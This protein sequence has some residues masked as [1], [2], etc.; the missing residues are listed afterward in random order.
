MRRRLAA[1]V[2]TIV[3]LALTYGLMVQFLFAKDKKL[4][5]AGGGQMDLTAWRFAG[6]GVIP[7]DGEWQ[8]YPDEL[9]SSA[10]IRDRVN[11]EGAPGTATIHVPGSW[12]KQMETLGK[13]T[14]RLQV[15]VGAGDAGK[16]FGL[17]TLSLQMSNRILVNGIEVGSSG[18]AADKL[19]YRA[20]NKPY[21]SYFTLQPGWNEIVVQV[22]N[23]DFQASSG[24]MNSISFG[25]SDQISRLRDSGII[26]D[27][28]TIACFLIIGLYFIGLYAQ[29]KEDHSLLYFGLVCLLLATFSSTRGERLLLILFDYVPYWL[30]IRLQAVSVYGVSISFFLYVYTAF[31]PYCSQRMVYAGVAVGVC[32]T[33]WALVF[34]DFTNTTPML[35]ITTVY[36]TLPYM[37][38]TYVLVLAALHR[39]EGSVYLVI[40]ALALNHY[41][42]IQSLN[43][44][45]NVALY[46]TVPFEV[47][48][49]LLM[50]ALMMSL[51]FSNAFKK[52]EQL[53]VQLMNVDKLKDEFL[54]RTS[55]EFK[56]PL[57]SVITISQ[58]MLEDPRHPL[59]PEQSEK[60]ELV[61]SVTKK[62]S[63]LVFDILDLSKLK[64]G[65]L[66]VNPIAVDVRSTVEMVLRIF[67]YL[68]AGKDVQ[69]INS[70]PEQ[71]PNA[72]AD[73]NRFR[74]ILNNLVDNAVKYTDRG[75]IEVLAV[76]QDGWLE[77]SV[78]DTGSGIAPD[79]LQHIFEPFQS[80]EST[81]AHSF[82]LGLSIVKQL[83]ELQHGRITVASVK[84]KGS[85]FTFSLPVAGPAERAELGTAHAQ[86][87]YQAPEYSFTTPYVLGS[88]AGEQTILIA[89]DH[90]A[91]LKILIDALEPL[92]YNLIAVQNGF[93]AVEQIEQLNSI[94]LV[95]LDLMMPGMS[96][97]DVCKTIRR[98]YSLL[99]MPVLMVTTAVEPQD[100][101]AAF[102]AGANDFLP[103]PFDTTELK[104]RVKGL[105]LMKDTLGQAIKM[106]MAFLQSQIKPHFLYNVLNTI[107]AL[108]Y[109]DE[110]KS[111][112][113]TIDLADYMRGSFRFSNTQ[114]RTSFGQ[115]LSL[116]RS[117]VEIEHA[118]FKDRL[119]VEYDIEE[120]M[121]GVSIPPLLLQPLVENA[122]R[123]GIG[124]RTEGGT[125]TISARA[126]ENH[127][128][129]EIADNGVGI[130]PERLQQ[131][132]RQES[133]TT[134]G[135]GLR[136]IMKRLKYE[137]NTEL[138][139]ESLPAIGTRVIV[140]IPL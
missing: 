110:E 2:I 67:S 113:L 106:E 45:S 134:Y 16:I 103:K 137:Y 127:Y 37:Y 36:G 117:Y 81:P 47:F 57:Q 124:S 138:R 51:R 9:L 14:Y 63:Q 8:F 97:Y 34:I 139:M 93:E 111:R 29:R 20:G 48:L 95:I 22:A 120:S 10:A 49:V 109:T 92:G 125:V 5:L 59:A 84:G 121:Q 82:G 75:T 133:G 94:D 68:T 104:A 62:L 11:R 41:S 100:K 52:V 80:F 44:Y 31:R 66:M 60:L 53:S 126:E 115:E 112:K 108:S 1:V 38:T 39:A 50:L 132:L 119:R 76:E 28:I 89:D 21:V 105:L 19:M 128:C 131:L 26:H 118:R 58:S 4:P 86:L 69:L 23:Y 74:Q 70:V 83:V 98:T 99:E 64:Q 15:R 91:N 71:L 55:H 87:K 35:L 114:K 135:V 90:Y 78:Q 18:I 6:D 79:E 46:S 73:E 102:E 56:A 123:H 122:I 136:N 42:M 30:Y 24:I 85:V 54:F 3:I 101:V 116:I 17:K 25:Y 88:H 7:L 129:F 140:Q 130:E 27:L 12:S 33:A 43:V 61:L 77:I 13:A 107:V 40:S 32:L 96:G 65:D 72:L